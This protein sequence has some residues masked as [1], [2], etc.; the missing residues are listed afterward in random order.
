MYGPLA[1]SRSRKIFPSLSINGW[2]SLRHD[3]NTHANETI[4]S[5]QQ[6]LLMIE[7]YYCCPGLLSAMH[8]FKVLLQN[9]AK[10]CANTKA[11]CYNELLHTNCL[12]TCTIV[13]QISIHIAIIFLFCFHCLICKVKHKQLASTVEPQYTDHLGTRGCSVY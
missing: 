9:S 5:L 8:V 13:Q 11:K 1:I 7:L 4:D 12:C 2:S 3:N 6:E 10:T